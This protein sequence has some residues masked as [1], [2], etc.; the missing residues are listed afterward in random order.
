MRTY[1]VLVDVDPK[2]DVTGEGIRPSLPSAGALS[3]RLTDVLADVTK[4]D[5]M[6]GWRVLRVRVAAVDS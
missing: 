5:G 1:T 3:S 6:V 4:H 2:E